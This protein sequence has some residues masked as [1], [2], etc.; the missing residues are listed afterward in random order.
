MSI[1][2]G[3]ETVTT[4]ESRRYYY[5][6]WLRVLAILVVFGFHNAR[7]FD[8]GD[9]HVKNTETSKGFTIFIV[10]TTQWIMPLFFVLSGMSAHY[11][12][13]FQTLGRYMWSKVLRLAVPLIVGMFT[14]ISLQV[15]LERLT[16]GDFTG[17][18]FE[19]LPQYFEGGYGLGGNF[20][21]MG[22]H[23]WYLEMLFVYSLLTLPLFL[24]LRSERMGPIISRLAGSLAKPC[25]IFL[26]AAPVILMKLIGDTQNNII[27]EN[28]WGGWAM[29]PHLGFFVTG[30]FIVLDSQLITSIDKHRIAALVLALIAFAILYMCTLLPAGEQFLAAPGGSV[31]GVMHSWFWLAAIIGFA[32]RYLTS[33]NRFL[34]Y[35]TEAVLPFYILHQTIILLI[36]YHIV[37]LDTSIVVKYVV[38]TTLSFMAIGALYESLIRRFNVLRF[39]FGMKPNFDSG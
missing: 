9:W 30:Y 5:I 21:W 27:G 32:H 33:T 31:V 2:K 39:L 10:F 8:S 3:N 12:L 7:F 17:S 38:V 19:F 35:A 23:L 34:R 15:Y 36:G 16:H 18:F 1:R 20:A 6:D 11:A 4:S 14:H 28:H 29:L 13:R 24:W 22:L 25:A 37:Q 26:L